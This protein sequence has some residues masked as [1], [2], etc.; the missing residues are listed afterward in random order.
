MSNDARPKGGHVA[1]CHTWRHPHEQVY[2]IGI[3]IDRQFQDLPSFLAA[4]AL[5]KTTTVLGYVAF[6]N[7][8]T[9]LGSPDQII[10]N[11]MHSVLISLVFHLRL[12][13][14]NTN[15]IAQMFLPGKY[16]GSSD[17]LAEADKKPALPH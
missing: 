8:L 14:E 6:Q 10:D 7:R 11:Q 15:R 9:S 5:D 4:L 1:H 16:G 17:L 3:G 13:F 2:V 12:P